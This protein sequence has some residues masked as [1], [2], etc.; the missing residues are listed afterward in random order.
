[1][2]SL[3]EHYPIVMWVIDGVFWMI[4]VLCWIITYI[5]APLESRKLGH[6]VSGVHGVAF[7]FFLIAGYFS[8]N[9]W[10]MLTAL[11]DFSLTYLPV[12]LLKEQLKKH[13]KKAKDE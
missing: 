13:L 1:M 5:G 9:K 4:G 11:L 3:Y 10:L 6:H 12:F 2:S 8:P 7:V